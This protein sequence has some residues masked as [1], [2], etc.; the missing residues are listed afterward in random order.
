MAEERKSWSAWFQR[1][2]DRR[3]EYHGPVGFAWLD[4]PDEDCD[5]EPDMA[6]SSLEH[7][8]PFANAVQ[9]CHG[10]DRTENAVPGPYFRLTPPTQARG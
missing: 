9:G 8:S 10:A 7:C 1:R 4:E 2:I 3:D 5:C 6:K